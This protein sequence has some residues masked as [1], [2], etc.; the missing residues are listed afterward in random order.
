MNT[1]PNI[2]RVVKLRRMKGTRGA[3]GMCGGEGREAK[4][5]NSFGGET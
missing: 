4:C 3:G 1:S 2:I 5:I